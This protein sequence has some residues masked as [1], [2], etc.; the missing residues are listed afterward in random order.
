M[1]KTMLVALWV[2]DTYFKQGRDTENRLVR[3]K[4]ALEKTAE[5]R[6]GVRT[7]QDWAK[8]EVIF[9]APEYLFSRPTEENWL[10]PANLWKASPTDPLNQG[11][12]RHLDESDKDKIKRALVALSAKHPGFLIVPGTVAWSISVK[13]HPGL[14]AA[15]Q[16][17]V[18][19]QPPGY[20]AGATPG[21]K[22]NRLVFFNM[23]TDKNKNWIGPSLTPHDKERLEKARLCLNT[24]FVLYDGKVVFV[25]SKQ[26]DFYEVLAPCMPNI[27]YQV[28]IPG[29]KCGVFEI[30]GN[31]YG[32]EI[33]FDH[34]NGVLKSQVP[35]GNTPLIHLITSAA[36]DV[37]VD[38]CDVIQGGYVV[39]AASDASRT[40]I[41]Y[42]DP[43]SLVPQRVESPRW[44]GI[45]LQR[46]GGPPPNWLGP[47]PPESYKEYPDIAGS[48]LWVYRIDIPG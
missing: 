28:A 35:V 41:W 23:L 38:N 32:I 37:N 22:R 21:Q 42:R 33:C 24:S 17:R 43:G 14:L 27:A 36:V 18:N 7:R 46:P 40:G 30:D 48:P 3:L 47:W 11:R 2:R 16:T 19:N 20:V 31:W 15:A 25:Y 39:H 4:A 44:L 29:D 5:I 8:P 10:D 13:D 1:P 12:N 6:K 9:V 34:Y 26:A 45:R